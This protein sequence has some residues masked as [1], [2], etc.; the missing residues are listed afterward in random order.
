MTPG[1]AVWTAAGRARPEKQVSRSA[2]CT[3]FT[4]GSSPTNVTF[5]TLKCLVYNLYLVPQVWRNR[6]EKKNKKIAQPFYGLEVKAWSFQFRPSQTVYVRLVPKDRSG[7]PSG[8]KMRKN[9][10]RN[11]S[12][13]SCNLIHLSAAD[14]YDHTVPNTTPAYLKDSQ[15]CCLWVTLFHSSTAQTVI[16]YY[17]GCTDQQRWNSPSWNLVVFEPLH[18]WP[19]P[20]SPTTKSL[21]LSI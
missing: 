18:F 13:T 1:L 9:I 2:T 14:L 15:I 3:G 8:R 16:Y 20:L 17:P 19:R 7:E 4:N 12:D 21:L 6:S 5:I 10:S 11:E